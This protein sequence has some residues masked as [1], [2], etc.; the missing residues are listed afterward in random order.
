MFHWKKKPMD[1]FFY[2]GA[3]AHSGPRPHHCRGFIISLRHTTL[4]RSPLDQWS[5]RRRDLYL[6]K[7][8]KLTRDRHPCHRRDSNPQSQQAS[9]RR[10]TPYTA[11]ALGSAN[12]HGLD[13]SNFI[14]WRLQITKLT[15]H[16]Y[17]L[18]LRFVHSSHIFALKNLQYVLFACFER[19]SFWHVGLG[20]KCVARLKFLTAVNINV[21]V[22]WCVATGSM[23]LWT[24]VVFEV[25]S[26]WKWICQIFFETSVRIDQTIWHHI[27]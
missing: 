14:C 23:T 17:L 9:C 24:S 25:K 16:S 12:P 1:I 11:R 21:A 10:P 7:H 3:T 22:L 15:W 27:S 20:K 2:H 4:S 18:F 5:A 26:L 6:T 8:I 13:L 19:S